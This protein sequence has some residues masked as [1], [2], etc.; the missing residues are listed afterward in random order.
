MAQT[1]KLRFWHTIDLDADR[2]TW[3][4]VFP[5]GPK[6]YEYK[7]DKKEIFYRF[8]KKGDYLFTNQKLDNGQ[9]VED[10]KF[11]H[12]INQ[13]PIERCRTRFIVTERYCGGGVSND[14]N[15]TIRHI[16]KFTMNDC[17]FDEDKCKIEAKQNIVDDYSCLKENEK[18]EFNILSVAPVVT[19][20]APIQNNFEFLACRNKD[21]LNNSTQPCDA[22]GGWK[23]FYEKSPLNTPQPQSTLYNDNT[24]DDYYN[25]LIE[26]DHAGWIDETGGNYFMRIYRY[27]DGNN[28]TLSGLD[29]AS[30]AVSDK[31]MF[32][33]TFD[34]GQSIKIGRWDIG[35]FITPA[36]QIGD[37]IL[38]MDIDDDLGLVFWLT[39]ASEI[40]AY[41]IDTGITRLVDGFAAVSLVSG[42]YQIKYADGVMVYHDSFTGEL[43]R[44]NPITFNIRVIDLV[45]GVLK[46]L[47][48]DA[49]YITWFDVAQQSMFLQERDDTTY[50]IILLRDNGGDCRWAVRDD[51]WLVFDDETPSRDQYKINLINRSIGFIV[52]GILNNPSLQI[53]NGWCFFH[54]G[55][56][57]IC[58]YLDAGT[59]G[60]T[61]T[62][63]QFTVS[64][65]HSNNH[66][67]LVAAGVERIFF[68]EWDTVG[69]TGELRVIDMANGTDGLVENLTTEMNCIKMNANEQVISTNEDRVD[70]LKEEIQRDDELRIWFRELITTICVGGTPSSPSGG[71]W[72]ILKNQCNLYGTATWV[73]Q[74]AMSAPNPV[75]VVQGGC[76]CTDDEIDLVFDPDECISISP[77]SLITDDVT[78]PTTSLNSGTIIGPVDGKE[79]SNASPAQATFYIEN[80]R[81]GSTYTW[82]YTG[83]GMTIISGQGTP[84][85]VMEFSGGTGANNVTCQEVNPCEAAPIALATH[86]YQNYAWNFFGGPSAITIGFIH[87]AD[88]YSGGTVRFVREFNN[89]WQLGGGFF[90]TGGTVTNSYV[91]SRNRNVYEVTHNGTATNIFISQTQ[92][93][94]TST[95]TVPVS[96]PLTPSTISQPAEV[97]PAAQQTF[98]V[99]APRPGCSYSWSVDAPMLIVGPNTGES[100]V[101]DINGAP[102]T[103]QI[104]LSEVCPVQPVNYQL[105]APC[106]ELHSDSWWWEIGEDISYTRNRL[107]KNVVEELVAFICPELDGIRSNLFQWNPTQPS[108]INYVYGGINEYNFL[109]IS[110]KSDIRNPNSSEPATIGNLTWKQFSE[111]L[112]NMEVFYIIENNILIIEHFSFFTG[113]VG[114]DTTQVPK[115][116]FADFQRRY[117]YAKEEMA[118]REK[119]T[120]ME[121]L[122][123][124]FVG[125]PIEYKDENGD[126]SLCVNDE[127]TEKNFKELTTDLKYIQTQPGQISNSGF[128]ILANTFDGTDYK[129]ITNPG[130]I[131]SLP[132][133]NSPMSLSVLQDRFMR[134]RRILPT[135]W[136]NRQFTS[137][138]SVQRFKKQEPFKV[139]LCC[140]E[141]FDP[142]DL[143][144]TTL[145]DGEVIS[146]EIDLKDDTIE[147]KLKYE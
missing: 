72:T 2:S 55:N 53:S 31:K 136:L 76:L 41:S 15:W 130:V 11:F 25:C 133:L 111:W 14:S 80:P 73:K 44:Y 146:G 103:A 88:T 118:R 114:L 64:V 13:D 119:Y 145:G 83:I 135:G 94:I 37:N 117:E 102:G 96:T 131:S 6:T 62:Y 67:I 40:Y 82:G 33:W 22:T 93:G 134:H 45:A 47:F 139:P 126:F 56:N 104:H 89:P 125:F 70:I 143:V 28:L 106:N 39:D 115:D 18:E 110:Q 27:A 129:V 138:E 121:A 99:T 8:E 60:S 42:E 34:N 90:V 128:V 48:C 144:K 4:E 84:V 7:K 120:M 127:T 59:N 32:A 124:D 108:L 57:L 3:R 109:T 116:E 43:R 147:L 51:E 74:P 95:A 26:K 10:Y 19:A 23:L 38:W 29:A 20:K 9:K 137:F 30:F 101:I 77:N 71:G 79:L 85:V 69:G 46:H 100:V 5:L 63:Y 35:Q 58:H 91:D 98:Y 17:K 112:E 1:N 123:A 68:S 50:E 54:N 12:E 141:E 142:I 78:N 16:G 86:P 75:E 92:G 49:G 21:F 140:D 87:E 122:N 66:N 81:D 107:L 132:I 61:I 97:C 52:N 113:N 36:S 24:K 65:G 105:V